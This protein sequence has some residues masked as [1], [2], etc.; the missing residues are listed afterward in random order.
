MLKLYHWMGKNAS[1][2]TRRRTSNEEPESHLRGGITRVKQRF[3]SL[4]TSFLTSHHHHPVW[5]SVSE[6]PPQFCCVFKQQLSHLHLCFRHDCEMIPINFSKASLQFKASLSSLSH[7]PFV[8]PSWLYP[9]LFSFLDR[10]LFGGGLSFCTVLVLQAVC[11]NPSPWA[12]LPGG[13]WWISRYKI[14]ILDIMETSSSSVSVEYSEMKRRLAH[15]Q[16][17]R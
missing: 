6:L 9:P 1:L 13:I 14:V 15:N 2:W 5:C 16:R 11:V 4:S 8:F 17:C 10:K 3:S 12:E 7:C